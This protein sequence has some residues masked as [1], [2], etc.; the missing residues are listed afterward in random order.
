MRQSAEG[1]C[2]AAEVIPGF[3]SAE[4]LRAPDQCVTTTQQSQDPPTQSLISQHSDEN[5][6][7]KKT[8]LHQS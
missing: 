8:R 2:A 5:S 6:S 1:R 7:S 4:V 3:K